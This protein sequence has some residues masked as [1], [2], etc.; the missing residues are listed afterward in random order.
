MLSVEYLDIYSVHLG[1]SRYM[2]IYLSVLVPAASCTLLAPRLNAA[3]LLPGP[4]R[5][6][7]SSNKAHQVKCKQFYS[8]AFPGI[9]RPEPAAGFAAFLPW[10]AKA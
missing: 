3:H 5:H 7:C 1:K 2:Q 4:T 9:L 8:T 10:Q 6:A